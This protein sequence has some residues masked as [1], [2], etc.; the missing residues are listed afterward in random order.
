MQTKWKSIIDPIVSL[1]LLQG[2]QLNNIALN[3]GTT[4]INHLLSR[5]QQGWLITDIQGAATIYR[6]E[7]FNDKTLTLTSNAAVT[8]S[9]WV[10]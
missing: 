10:Y 5:M 9:L 7:P 8:I 6:S 2:L 4:A 3:S 1:P